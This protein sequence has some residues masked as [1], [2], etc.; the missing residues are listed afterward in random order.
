[1][2]LICGLGNPGR[3]YERHRH[4][5]GFQVLDVLAARWKASFNGNKFA[6]V[7]PIVATSR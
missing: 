2:K 5:I 3:E 4:N 7:K 1:M 6:K